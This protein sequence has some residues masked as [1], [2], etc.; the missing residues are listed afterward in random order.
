MNRLAPISTPD[1][2]SLGAIL[3]FDSLDSSPQTGDLNGRPV[4]REAETGGCCLWECLQAIFCFTEEEGIQSK[5]NRT[6]EQLTESSKKELPAIAE[7]TEEEVEMSER[8]TSSQGGKD[9]S[10]LVN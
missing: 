4:T 3:G 2:S 7:E 8:K 1:G 5:K 10:I 9:E 6:N